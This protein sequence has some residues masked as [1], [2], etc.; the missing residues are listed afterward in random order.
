MMIESETRKS[1][2]PTLA[3]GVETSHRTSAEILILTQA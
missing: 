3:Q 1:K 2:K